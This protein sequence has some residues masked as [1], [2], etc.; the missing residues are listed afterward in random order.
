MSN[1]RSTKKQ[2]M[3]SAGIDLTKEAKNK[4]KKGGKHKESTIGDY[5]FVLA[6]GRCCGFK[7]S[8]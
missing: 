1:Q 6:P 3:V 7:K 8:A 2:I 5:K 4:G